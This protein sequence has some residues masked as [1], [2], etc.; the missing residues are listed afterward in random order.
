[1]KDWVFFIKQDPIYRDNEIYGYPD[2]VIIDM[3]VE[4]AIEELL[5][6]IYKAIKMGAEKDGKA[7]FILHGKLVKAKG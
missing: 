5:P 7:H 1:M 4:D 2:T 6:S 3:T